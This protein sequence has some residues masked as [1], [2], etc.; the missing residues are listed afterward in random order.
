MGSRNGFVIVPIRI[1][2]E[3]RYLIER[4]QNDMK[5]ISLSGTIRGLLETHPEIDRLALEVYAGVTGDVP[6]SR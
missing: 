6:A 4:Y 1:P 3:L 5:I 2:V